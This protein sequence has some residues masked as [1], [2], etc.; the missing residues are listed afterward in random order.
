MLLVANDEPHVDKHPCISP[1]P[2]QVSKCA[3]PSERAGG[4]MPRHMRPRILCGSKVETDVQGGR[5]ERTGNNAMSKAWVFMGF[6]GAE[7]SSGW[8]FKGRGRMARHVR[9][10]I[11]SSGQWERVSVCVCTCLCVGVG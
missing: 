10:R 5:R 3:N 7:L 2:L 4:R 8:F 1:L 9:P 11:L 6:E